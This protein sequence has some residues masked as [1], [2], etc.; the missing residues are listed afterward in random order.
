MY[1]K[2]G[3]L[4]VLWNYLTGNYYCTSNYAVFTSHFF[5][6]NAVHIRIRRYL[7]WMLKSIGNWVVFKW[8]K[9]FNLTQ[10]LI[11]IS[12][13][14]VLAEIT[15]CLHVWEINFSLLVSNVSAFCFFWGLRYWLFLQ[16]HV[17]ISQELYYRTVQ[18]Q[19]KPLFSS[20][21]TDWKG[22]VKKRP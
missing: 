2:P 18:Y 8:H 11:F 17:L 14:L 19:E 12:V 16:Q 15:V 3:S 13:C 22:L 20:K 9:E 5:G 10:C 1:F 6:E 21:I 4:L 7:P